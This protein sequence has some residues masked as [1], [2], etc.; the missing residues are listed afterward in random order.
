MNDV[1]LTEAPPLPEWLARDPAVRP[2]AVKSRRAPEPELMELSELLDLTPIAEESS[3]DGPTL[4]TI[5]DVVGL[6]SQK[7]AAA[8]ATSRRERLAVKAEVDPN[9]WLL[10]ALGVSMSAV[11]LGA[12]IMLFGGYGLI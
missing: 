7:V 8:K 5:D 2:S 3:H 9:D 1:D 10:V 12:L 4:P 11:M 6:P